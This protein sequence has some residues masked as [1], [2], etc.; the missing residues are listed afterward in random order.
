MYIRQ[1]VFFVMR[2]K[3]MLKLCDHTVL[4]FRVLCNKGIKETRSRK[5]LSSFIFNI[6]ER[7][8]LNLVLGACNR[9]YFATISLVPEPRI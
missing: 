1:S 4:T 8:S 7:I 2:P 3:E 6:T 9:C 5:L